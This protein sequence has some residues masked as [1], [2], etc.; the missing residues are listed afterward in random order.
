MAFRTGS[1]ELGFSERRGWYLSLSRNSVLEKS[2]TLVGQLR[3]LKPA[4]DF[5]FPGQGLVGSKDG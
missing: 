4:E 1:R 3:N 5:Y 2:S